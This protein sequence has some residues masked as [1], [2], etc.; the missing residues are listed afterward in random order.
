[1]VTKCV[2][3]IRAKLGTVMQF[4]QKLGQQMHDKLAN[5]LSKQRS[6][7]TVASNIFICET[8]TF[9]KVQLLSLH[10]IKHHGQNPLMSRCAPRLM[11]G[12]HAQKHLEM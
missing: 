6:G 12:L 3:T 11:A 5:K 9:S 4:E 8:Q 7:L 2:A 1:M 10:S